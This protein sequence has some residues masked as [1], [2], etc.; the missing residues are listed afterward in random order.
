MVWGAFWDIGRSGYYIM[1]RDFE[2]KKY[3]YSANSYLKVLNIEVE[4]IFATLD[5][6]YAFI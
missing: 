6:G 1:G 3:R 5:E 4:P 2:S